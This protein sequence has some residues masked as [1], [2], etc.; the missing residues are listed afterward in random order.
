MSSLADILNTPVESIER[1]PILPVGTY[2]AQVKK[3]DFVTRSSAK[4]SWEIIE[5]S[6]QLIEPMDDVDAN[7]LRKFGPLA[8]AVRRNSFMFD[9]DTSSDESK[10]KNARTQYNLKQFFE[11]LGL[12]P[13]GSVKQMLESAIGQQCL[14][15]IG[16]RP[17]SN[18]AEVI[19]DEIKK[20]AP[21]R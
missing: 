1:P 7:S 2:R 21:L 3:K 12:D 5:F 16:W 11:H 13:S 20:T 15:V 10:Q 14:I 6:M 19:Y 17:D 18:N 4:G 9:S 8:S